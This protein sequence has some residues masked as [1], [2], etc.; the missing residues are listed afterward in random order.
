[1]KKSL[2]R[3]DFQQVLKISKTYLVLMV[4]ILL[5][6][7]HVA[8][9][10]NVGINTNTPDASAALDIQSAVGKNQGVLFPSVALT[11]VGDATTILSPRNGLIV[12][13][14]G[15]GALTPAGLYF[16]SG[17]A[18]APVWTKF[19]SSNS[20]WKLTGNAGTTVGTNFIGTT[21]VTDLVI[22][23]NA[24]ERLHVTSGG[25]TGIGETSPSYTL[26]VKY[27]GADR[28]ARI[29]NINNA[30][31]SNGLLISTTRT[32]S[33]AY[34]LNLD[35]GGISCFYARS[36]GNVGIGTNTPLS[37]LQVNGGSMRISGTTNTNAETGGMLI[38]DNS[39]GLGGGTAKK[40]ERATYV[41]TSG[42][43]NS[44]IIFDD[45]YIT[46]R[47]RDGGFTGYL[48]ATSKSGQTGTYT[49]YTSDGTTYSPNLATAG[50]YVDIGYDF[51][52]ANDGINVTMTKQGLSNPPVV[53]KIFALHSSS[54]AGS[55]PDRWMI[56][57][58]AYYF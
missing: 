21:D 50:T 12:W 29:R 30:A 18:V 3:K 13:N 43:S 25:N 55:S 54:T 7:T 58:E 53:Y 1:M 22:K 57:V 32:A 56:I 42:T 35:A 38:Y 40:V 4:F 6:Q 28:V 39:S 31:S 49:V 48:N 52:N 8:H 24:N 51:N 11:A 2:Q 10:Q 41:E 33:D 17:T 9:G 16:N 45:P 23:T 37:K 44:S 14:D 15:T 19:E 26:D 47:V 36:D 27:A 20:N 46:L 34:I 5:M